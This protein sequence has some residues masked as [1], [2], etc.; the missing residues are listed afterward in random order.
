M[1]MLSKKKN[2]F[3]FLFLFAACFSVAQKPAVYKIDDLLK[4]IHNKSDTIYIVNFWAT[5]CKPCVQELPDFESFYSLNRSGLIK[6]ILVSLDFKEDLDKKLVP[7][8]D[9]NKYSS[10][11][12][13]L[14]E[15]NGDY[16]INKIHPSWS[17]A[18][19]ATY[20]TTKNKKK[21]GI[22]EKKMDLA[23]LNEAVNGFLK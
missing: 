18:I 20:I 14:D 23:L 2:N 6:I 8:L 1:N 21:E 16:F 13:L 10:E 11:V 22:F 19:P 9:K 12:V 4:R 3:L 15:I 17:G 5:W 7:F